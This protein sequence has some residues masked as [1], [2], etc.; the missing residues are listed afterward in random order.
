MQS[1]SNVKIKNSIDSMLNEITLSEITVFM[2]C[3]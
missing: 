3:M 2:V 1:F